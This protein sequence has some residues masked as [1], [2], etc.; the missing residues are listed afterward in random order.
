[1]DKDNLKVELCPICGEAIPQKRINKKAKTCSKACGK[2]LVRQAYKLANPTRGISPGKVGA[3][4]EL[5][6][7]CD[8]IRRG[9]DVFRA[10]SPSCSCDLAV[11]GSD[12]EFLRIEVT[13]GSLNI[14]SGKAFYPPHDPSRYD[15]IA[16]VIGDGVINYYPDIKKTPECVAK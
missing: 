12:G 7:S 13:T 10:V 5:I 11:L 4:N 6:V 8:L 3:L 15:V 16:V 1:M 2:E 14:W 9:Y